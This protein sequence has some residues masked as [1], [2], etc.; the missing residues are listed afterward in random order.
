MIS[1]ENDRERKNIGVKNV[2]GG[3]F[4]KYR[5]VEVNPKGGI[6]AS[7]NSGNRKKAKV[8]PSPLFSYERKR[9]T[10]RKRG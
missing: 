2:N 4:C 3:Y 7:W 5:S 6:M 10:P 8:I 1:G 9:K